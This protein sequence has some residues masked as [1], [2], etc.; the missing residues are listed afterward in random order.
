MA[1]WN[2]FGLFQ[3]SRIYGSTKLANLMFAK[4]LA[5]R[6]KSL[7]HNIIVNALH[8]GAV[9]TGLFRNIPYFGVI[10]KWLIGILYYTPEVCFPFYCF[11]FHSNQLLLITLVLLNLWPQVKLGLASS[12][13]QVYYGSGDQPF[14]SPLLSG[15]ILWTV[16]ANFIELTEKQTC[17]R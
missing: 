14:K 5:R 12:C 17:I 16:L 15:S 8:P 13:A 9:Q 11:H 6:F 7:N 10:I 1:F 4:E 2:F 3:S